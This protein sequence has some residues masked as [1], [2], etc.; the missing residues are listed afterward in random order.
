MNAIGTQLR[1]PIPV[2]SG[3][4]RW[5][6]EN[7]E[8]ADAGRGCRTRLTRETNFSGTNGDREIIFIFQDCSADHEQDWQPH[9][10]D[11]YIELHTYRSYCINNSAASTC[12]A[13]QFL[14]YL[15]G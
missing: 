3:L 13:R 4:T 6:M 8:Q 10:I 9:P 2:N 14:P 15:L 5:R 11:P 12:T 1:D 7:D